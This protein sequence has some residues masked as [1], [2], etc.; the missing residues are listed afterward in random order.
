MISKAFI[1]E[2]FKITFRDFD[3]NDIFESIIDQKNLLQ[4]SKNTL[5]WNHFHVEIL[6]EPKCKPP[7][8]LF[9][10]GYRRGPV[11]IWIAKPILEI[12]I[13]GLEEYHEWFEIF[14][15]IFYF[16]SLDLLNN[17]KQMICYFCDSQN[18]LS[19]LEHLSSNSFLDR[20]TQWQFSRTTVTGWR[21]SSLKWTVPRIWTV[22]S[23]SGRSW[24]KVD[25]LLIKSMTF[26]VI[27]LWK[28][29]YIY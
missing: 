29:F 4:T 5:L 20:S 22:L 8:I 3:E 9:S 28:I 27:S 18:F 2:P 7:R 14:T 13:K 23:Q 1:I 24:T 17:F 11:Q 15:L 10:T 6:S 19:H 16:H 12:L 21:E 26:M 25:V